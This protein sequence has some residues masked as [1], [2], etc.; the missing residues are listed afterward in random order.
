MMDLVSSLNPFMALMFK[1]RLGSK[2]VFWICVHTH[3]HTHTHT[4]A[5]THAHT[6]T[7]THADTSP[8]VSATVGYLTAN[9]D[10]LSCCEPLESGLLCV[11]FPCCHVSSCRRDET[12][13]S[14]QEFTALSVKQTDYRSVALA[15]GNVVGLTNTR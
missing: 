14:R 6:H 7:H 12:G 11:T 8:F 15:T 2:Y 9:P 10:S 13:D 4:H 3:T 1:V 5:R